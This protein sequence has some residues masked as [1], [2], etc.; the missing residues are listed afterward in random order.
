MLLWL[1]SP[2]SL[3]FSRKTKTGYPHLCDFKLHLEK[4]NW[5][6]FWCGQPAE[7]WI[8]NF[9]L[10]WQK[11][12]HYALSPSRVRLFMTP[13]TVACRQAPLSMGILW[14]RILEWVAM[15]SSR[16]SSQPRDQTQVS[17]T[18]CR[19]FTV[20]VTREAQEYVHANQTPNNLSVSNGCLQVPWLMWLD[21]PLPFTPPNICRSNPPPNL[22]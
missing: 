2:F 6:K 16:G 20:W 17:C 3:C 19:F 9:C 12:C 15:P 13:W 4:L 14:A 21:S 11:H 1:C 10:F 5:A 7:T 22:I 18:A 8:Q